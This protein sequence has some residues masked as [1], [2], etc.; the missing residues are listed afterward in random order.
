MPESVLLL[1]FIIAT[2]AA[3]GVGYGSGLGGFRHLFQTTI[4]SALIVLVITVI[5]DIDRPRR[6]LITVSQDSMVLLQES[7]S[8]ASH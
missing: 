6:G 7:M 8:R 1:L 5:I 3:L 4:M 2:V